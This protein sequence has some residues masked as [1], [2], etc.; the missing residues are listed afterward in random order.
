M[1][2]YLTHIV[3]ATTPLRLVFNHQVNIHSIQALTNLCNVIS[4]QAVLWCT[5]SKLTCLCANQSSMIARSCSRH[6]SVCLFFFRIVRY[7][8]ETAQKHKPSIVF[9]DDCDLLFS[10]S[11]ENGSDSVRRVKTELLVQM[12]GNYLRNY[13]QQ[14]CT[15]SCHSIVAFT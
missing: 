8:F 1:T 6:L 13:L 14:V 4:T 3:T 7:L 11:G 2:D 5:Q 9:I 15:S 12:H 10:S